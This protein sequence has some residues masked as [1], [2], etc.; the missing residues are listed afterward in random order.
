MADEQKLRN[1]VISHRMLNYLNGAFQGQF[2]FY[3][4][5]AQLK[6]THFS[7][8][9]IS[10]IKE[11]ITRTNELIDK[12]WDG[13]VLFLEERGRDQSKETE[14]VRDMLKELVTETLNL[15][16]TTQQILQNR[17]YY[18]DPE[19]VKILAAAYGRSCYSKD[20]YIRG[21]IKFAQIFSDRDMEEAWQNDLKQAQAD[22]KYANEFIM[23]LKK[24]EEKDIS[25]FMHLHYTARLLPGVYSAQVHDIYQL[26]CAGFGDFSYEAAKIEP[27][28]A[29]L[30]ERIDV[31]AIE[32]G[33]WRAYGFSPDNSVV[34]KK[35]GFLN[36]LHACEWATI[37]VDPKTSSDWL[38]CRFSPLEAL[39]WIA[40]NYS[41]EE[42][43]ESIKKGVLSPIEK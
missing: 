25:F 41:P 28:E 16:Y 17:E 34:W 27:N 32:A 30:W 6:S 36:P 23:A 31:P 11:K 19:Q 7:L 2:A 26:L 10:T 33:Y 24:D 8:T 1:Q 3:N 21:F 43:L 12:L 35:E 39:N 18:K 4:I 37:G 5:L 15:A 40:A 14:E 38:K 22:V 42:A 13:E 9:T 20:N 29:R